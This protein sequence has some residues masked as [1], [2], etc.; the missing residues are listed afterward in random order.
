[1][2][3]IKLFTFVVGF[4]LG[5]NLFAGTI[6][7]GATPEPHAVI[8]EQVIKPLKDK[9]VNLEIR[10]F[11]DYVIPNMALDDGSISANFFQHQPYLDSFNAEKK[12]RLVP[13]A[14]VH[15][16]PMGVYSQRIKNLKDIKT[17][18][19]VAIPNDPSNGSRALKILAKEGLITLKDVPLPSVLDITA[20]SKKLTF[21]ELDAPQ[22]PRVLGEVDIA[23]INTNFALLANLNPLHDA[24]AIEDKNSPYANIVVVK[25][26]NENNPDIKALV[27]VLQ[28]D[29]I[30]DFINNH[31]KGA[32]IPSF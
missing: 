31:Y 29:S 27:E 4:L 32:I 19:V 21:K 17:N 6:I 22:L 3:Y 20:N 25:K 9:G 11:N 12:T 14:K 2:K 5:S 26:G 16:E 30:R 18:A 28:S 13:V 1:M 23:I 10:E 15:L 24:I 8:L 7:V